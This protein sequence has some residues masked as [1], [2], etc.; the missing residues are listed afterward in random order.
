[1]SVEDGTA[2]EQRHAGSSDADTGGSPK[3]RAENLTKQF[4]RIVAV[5]DVSLDILPS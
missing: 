5:E 1:M 4:G 3:L 2:T